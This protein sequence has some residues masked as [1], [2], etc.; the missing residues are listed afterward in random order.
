[1]LGSETRCSQ[2]VPNPGN[3][4]S[5]HSL[6]RP[7]RLSPLAQW[8]RP[9]RPWLVPSAWHPKRPNAKFAIA[10]SALLRSAR[11]PESIAGASTRLLSLAQCDISAGRQ[12]WPVL[13]ERPFFVRSV[14][15]QEVATQ[16]ASRGATEAV[17]TMFEFPCCPN[18]L[19]TTNYFR[20][21]FP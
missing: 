4:F 20:G 11:D 16:K 14:A 21:V 9:T 12:M 7:P 8:S 1:M 5:T 10:T 3:L 17:R 13:C 18:T 6:A 2:W 19:D 15:A